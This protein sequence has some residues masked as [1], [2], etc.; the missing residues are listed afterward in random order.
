M[1]IVKVE[2]N[3]YTV[4]PLYQWDANQTL[5]VYG[6]SLATVPEI[7]YTNAAM[8]RAL[9]RQ[10]TMDA[11]GVI[12]AEIPNSLLQKP[13]KI[14]AYICTYTGGLFRSLYKLEI[15][16]KGRQQPSDYTLTDDPEVY[17]FNAL[18]NKVD[19]VVHDYT[20]I[21]KQYA[22][23]VALVKQAEQT[24]EDAV[25]YVAEAA[26]EAAEKAVREKGAEALNVYTKEQVL[27]AA[28]K[29]LYSMGTESTPDDALK[30][31]AEL[32]PLLSSG[33]KVAV[34][35]YN[36]TN[37][38]GAANP[39]TLNVGFKPLFFY[40]S[41]GY[42]VRGYYPQTFGAWFKGPS[43]ADV[44]SPFELTVTWGD[45]YVSW[46]SP[47]GVAKQC[48]FTTANTYVVIGV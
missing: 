46:Y 44:D 29:V 15:P 37:A 38:Y 40:V 14:T 22:A 17:S 8:D 34:G 33:A 21:G 10:A 45:T 12:R 6:L 35:I 20:E 43:G 19:Q 42:A 28:T 26:E 24:Y 25:T 32:L 4:D 36:G 3:T 48:N 13:Y 31:L 30:K 9:V 27:S 7:H 47:N 41:N 1:S 2:K 39:V 16:V 5:E 11:A 23:A 18:E